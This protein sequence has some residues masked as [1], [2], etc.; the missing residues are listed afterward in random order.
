MAEA[1]ARFCRR[2]TI[3]FYHLCRDPG[4]ARQ[5]RPWFSNP[6]SKVEV[7]TRAGHWIMLDRNDDVNAAVTAWIDAL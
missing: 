4:Q 1:S 3:P 7:W 5:M 2:L 6:K